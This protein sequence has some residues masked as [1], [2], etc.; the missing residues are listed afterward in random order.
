MRRKDPRH[1]RGRA[2]GN[3][4]GRVRTEAQREARRGRVSALS[5]KSRRNLLDVVRNTEGLRWFLT[6]T[7]QGPT[8]RDDRETKRH[9]DL[10]KRWLCNQGISFVWKQEFGS[11]GRVH[12]HMMT[13]GPID[14]EAAARRWAGIVVCEATPHLVVSGPARDLECVERYMGKR[15]CD[16]SH[17]VPEGYANMGRW[18]GRGG[19]DSK[20]MPLAIIKGTGAEIAKI[21]RTLK[22]AAAAR[23]PGRRR[24]DNGVTSQTLYGAGGET[25]TSAVIRY[26]EYLGVQTESQ[27]TE[28]G[29]KKNPLPDEAGAREDGE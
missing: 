25:M 14:Q 2:A 11:R 15:L 19:P 9:L 6:L 1:L 7:Y 8:P 18:W 27:P 20:P 13:T 22:K 12:F 29:E 23:E 3:D 21:V 4:V 10:F 5:G 16:E 28:D 17:R 24:R 26:G